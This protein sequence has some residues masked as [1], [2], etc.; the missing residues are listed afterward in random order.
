MIT[1]SE[2]VGGIG[3]VRARGRLIVVGGHSRHVGKTTVVAA[4]LTALRPANW[5][6]IKISS[7]S[8]G[9]GSGLVEE[10]D[11]HSG[12]PSARYLQAGALRAFLLRAPDERMID[13]SDTVRDLIQ[14]GQD[15]IAESN[16]LVAC[17]RPDLVLFATSP[18]I[19]DWKPSANLCLEAADAVVVSGE[20]NWLESAP[21]SLDRALLSVPQF[22]MDTGRQCVDGLAAWLRQRLNH[23]TFALPAPRECGCDVRS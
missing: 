18:S 16:R 10:T 20:G 21:A 2:D 14:S 15:V 11:P 9:S 5:V 8:H 12:S 23:S 6:A 17:F 3:P 13:A 4:A 22:R 1:S 19:S 7:H